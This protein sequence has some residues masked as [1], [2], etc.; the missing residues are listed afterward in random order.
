MKLAVYLSPMGV[1]EIYEISPPNLG[2]GG[3]PSWKGASSFPGDAGRGPDRD[4]LFP[5]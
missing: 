4:P 1:D 5:E 3:A 2:V